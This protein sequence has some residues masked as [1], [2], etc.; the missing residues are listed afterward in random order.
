MYP[1]LSGDYARDIIGEKA[2]IKMLRLK[3]FENKVRLESLLEI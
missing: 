2:I 1:T 3:C